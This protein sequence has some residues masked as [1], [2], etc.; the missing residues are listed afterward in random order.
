M[1]NLTYEIYLA[2]PRV[3]ERIEREAR[4]ARAEAMSRYLVAP[5]AK[6][7][8]RTLRR[9]RRRPAPSLQMSGIALARG[10]VLRVENARDIF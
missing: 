7:I 1:E 8:G 9:A 3:R 6:L 5:L 4:R 10:G 2:D